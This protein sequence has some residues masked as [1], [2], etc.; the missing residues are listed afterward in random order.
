MLVH[1]TIAYYSLLFLVWSQNNVQAD[2]NNEQSD[3]NSERADVELINCMT[4]ITSHD[5]IAG[6]EFSH[7]A[8]S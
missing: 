8:W 1:S 3:I 7:T 2:A 5:E 4:E 6:V